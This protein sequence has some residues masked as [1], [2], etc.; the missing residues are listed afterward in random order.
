MSQADFKKYADLE[1]VKCQRYKSIWKQATNPRIK[2]KAFFAWCVKSFQLQQIHIY[3]PEP[4]TPYNRFSMNEAVGYF[5]NEFA[6]SAESIWCFLLLPRLITG[7]VFF[8]YCKLPD[9]YVMSE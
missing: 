5:W 8:S 3:S 9:A 6:V 1:L 7:V 2:D 4:M